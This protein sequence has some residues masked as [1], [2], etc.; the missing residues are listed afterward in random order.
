M[1]N[2]SGGCAGMIGYA[3]VV[4]LILLLLTTCMGGGS[5]SSS[6]S[7]ASSASETAQ[8]Y[9]TTTDQVLKAQNGARRALRGR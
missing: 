1:A 3:A 5:G 7:R 6:S 8:K 9:G 2:N 4:I